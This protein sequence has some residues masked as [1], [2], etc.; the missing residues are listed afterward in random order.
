MGETENQNT[1][2]EFFVCFEGQDKN[3]E[4]KRCG[5]IEI[6]D[7]ELEDFDIL[8]ALGEDG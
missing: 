7:N 6:K 5:Y 8:E 3:I 1:G 4:Y 2:L